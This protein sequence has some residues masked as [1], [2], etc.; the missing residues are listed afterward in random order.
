MSNIFKTHFFFKSSV[1]LWSKPTETG[2][3]ILH[4]IHSF[5]LS[6]VLETDRK[7]G[8]IFVW[9][10]TFDCLIFWTK[11]K[12]STLV[13]FLTRFRLVKI[14]LLNPFSGSV[15]KGGHVSSKNVDRKRH[16]SSHPPFI[17]R[18]KSRSVGWQC[19]RKERMF[20]GC[21]LSERSSFD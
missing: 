6:C 20:D 18:G 14:P 19:T 16:L 2:Y 12:Y 21:S 13:F 5:V 7:K 17:V 9:D 3:E 4:G 11:S 1:Y 15:S 8:M 10:G